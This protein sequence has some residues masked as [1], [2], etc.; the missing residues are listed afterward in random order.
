MTERNASRAPEAGP[1]LVSDAP[2][3]DLIDLTRLFYALVQRRRIVICT[4]GFFLAMAVLYVVLAARVYEATSVVELHTRRPRIVGEDGAYVSD[5][6]VSASVIA[7]AL[8]THFHKMQSDTVRQQVVRELRRQA[9]EIPGVGGFTDSE[10]SFFLANRVKFT[11][12]I[13]TYLVRIAVRGPT[14]EFAGALANTYARVVVEEV[15]NSTK[16]ASIDAVQWLQEQITSYEQELLNNEAKVIAFRQKH[17]IDG[18]IAAKTAADQALMAINAELVAY[19]T[20]ATTLRDLVATLDAAEAT[21]ELSGTLPSTVPRAEIIQERLKAYSDALNDLKRLGMR[22]TE[23]HPLV[24]Q[25]QQVVD[26]L[27]GE[28]VAEIGRS[29]ETAKADLLLVN[30][31]VQSIESNKTS[32]IT[33]GEDIQRLINAFNTDVIPL[34]RALEASDSSYKGLLARIEQARLSIDEDTSLL[35]VYEWARP[36]TVPVAPRSS[37]IV[38]AALILGL[39]AGVGLALLV[40]LLQDMIS[41]PYDIETELKQNLLGLVP[42]VDADLNAAEMARISHTDTFSAFNESLASLRASLLTQGHRRAGSGWVIM[43][44]SVVPQEG[45]TTVSCNLAISMTKT[46]GRVLLI[47]GDMRRPRLHDVFDIPRQ[48]QLLMDVLLRPEAGDEV[49]ATVPQPTDIDRLHVTLGHPVPGVSP[50]EVLENGRFDKFLAWARRNYDIILV[51][52]PPLGAASDALVFGRMSDDVVLV[53]RYNKSRKGAL[54]HALKDLRKN[55]APL[56]GLVLNDFRPDL[57]GSVPGYS[58]Y[59]YRYGT[60]APAEEKSVPRKAGARV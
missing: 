57:P 49:F 6:A 5:D 39:G 32:Q 43:L 10:L 53:C 21:P 56:T 24:E 58:A 33:G 27:R 18:L 31:Y 3:D 22:Y 35:T 48:R 20:R 9:A 1:H 47:D 44:S 52:T 15:K 13:G 26:L 40:H 23:R 54:R 16:Q 38:A 2:R 37:L 28:L 19:E 55:R 50:T 11:R 12:V 34:Q 45:K 7:D 41:T 29:R 42:H 60:Y 25:Q 4:V 8:N 17:N 59:G 51:D 30:A 36:S 14:P 46:Y